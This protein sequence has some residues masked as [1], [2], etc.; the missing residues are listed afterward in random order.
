[1][2]LRLR[3][4]PRS[5]SG[6]EEEAGSGLPA[7]ASVGI[8]VK[9]DVDSRYR[10]L[11]AQLPVDFVDHLSALRSPCDIGLIRHDD[12][13]ESGGLQPTKGGGSVR[14]D[15]QL[16]Q[17]GGWMRPALADYGPVDDPITIEEHGWPGRTGWVVM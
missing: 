8:V 15:L 9:T 1:M 2:K 11:P 12:Q 6:F 16:V 10:Q 7:T 14:I 3:S 13:G 17:G 4:S 5:C